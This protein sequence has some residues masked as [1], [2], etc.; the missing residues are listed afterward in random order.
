[1]FVDDDDLSVFD[2]VVAVFFEES[3]SFECLFD[4]VDGVEFFF[5]DVV[6][7]KIAL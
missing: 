2:N 3:T 6:D 7:I 1:M 4:V 5:V